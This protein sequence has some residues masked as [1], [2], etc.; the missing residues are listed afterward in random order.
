MPVRL[1][2]LSTARIN[3]EILLGASP[4]DAVEVVAVGSRDRARAEAYAQQKGIPCAHGSYEELL[5]DPEVDAIYNSLPNSL[6]VPWTL[7]ALDAGKH[8]RYV[9]AGGQIVFDKWHNSSGA[10]EAAHGG[11]G[12]VKILGTVTAAQIA[13]LSK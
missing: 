7:R 9:G 1:G 8:I 6:H 3:D 13:A 4:S 2:L 5:S 11:G 10:F 12:T